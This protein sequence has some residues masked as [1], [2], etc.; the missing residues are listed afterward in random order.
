MQIKNIFTILIIILLFSAQSY[1]QLSY[2]AENRDA[3]DRDC[4]NDYGTH[5]GT[6][7]NGVVAYS[8]CNN[9]CVV[10]EA[11]RYQGTYT[12]VKWQCVEF[13]RR[14]LL[15]NYGVI[16]G[17]VDYA[18]DIWDKIDHYSRVKD[19]KEIKL[20]A[21]L[22]GSARAPV[23][24]DLLIYAK[25]LLGTGHVAVVVAADNK[26]NTLFIAE[27]NYSNEKWLNNFSRKISYV[28]KDGRYWLLEPYLIGW[29]HAEIESLI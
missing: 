22:N 11:E 21:L 1:F 10:F 18:I 24:G 5:L 17:D 16:Y 25:A 19:N 12:G 15:I 20:T 8:N 28:K 4:V 14:W 9:D 26:T 2:A 23:K 29:K 27:Q 13:A 3:C 6:T 7:R